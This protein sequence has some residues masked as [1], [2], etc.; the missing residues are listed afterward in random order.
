MNMTEKIVELLQEDSSISNIDL[1]KKIGLAPSSCLLRVK[2]LKEQNILKKFTVIVDE[3]KLGYEITCFAKVYVTPL[4][5]ENSQAFIEETK[6]I[7]EVVYLFFFKAYS[8][9][10]NLFVS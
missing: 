5:R 6:K 9:G 2:N 1:S 8:F 4:N 7:P 10:D 3:K